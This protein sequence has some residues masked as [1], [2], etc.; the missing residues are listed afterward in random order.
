MLK[1]RLKE[2]RLTMKYDK[3]TEFA[4]MLGV[5][6]KQYMSWENGKSNPK[7]ELAYQIAKKLNLKVTDIWSLND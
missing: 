7:L 1:C 6:P 3:R 4:E 2:I 5:N